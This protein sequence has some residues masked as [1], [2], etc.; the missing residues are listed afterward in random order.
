[1]AEVVEF[2][3]LDGPDERPPFLGGV[4]EHGAVRVLGVPH[5]DHAVPVGDLHA[6]PVRA[7]ARLAPYTVLSLSGFQ[8]LHSTPPFCGVRAANYRSTA[9]WLSERHNLV[10]IAA[11]ISRVVSRSVPRL[12]NVLNVVL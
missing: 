8:R 11:I 7:E 10:I 9:R 4:S 5:N 6:F 1:A 2:G 12:N 3:S